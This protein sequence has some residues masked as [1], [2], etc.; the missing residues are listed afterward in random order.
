[1]KL[2]GSINKY[3]ARIVVKGF[4]KKKLLDYFDTYAP[5]TH[6]TSI[7]MLIAIASLSMLEIHQV[8]IKIVFFNIKLD[9]KIIYNNQWPLVHQKMAIKSIIG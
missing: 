8:D 7:K 6:I 3:K 4:R 2:D 1:M 9:E 5:I